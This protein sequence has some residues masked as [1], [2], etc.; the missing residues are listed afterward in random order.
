MNEKQVPLL[1]RISY[2]LGDTA[3]NLIFA[4]VTSYLMFFYTD[5]FGLNMAAVGTLFLVA[6]IIDAFDGPAYG[7][8]IDRTSTKWGKSRPYFLWLAVPFGVVAVL[9]FMTPDL[10]PGGK[11]IYAYVTYILLGVLYAGVNIPLSSLLPSLT[12]SS[13]E[14]TVVNT[15][16]MVGGQV[17]GLIVNAAVLPLVAFFGG[18]NQQDGFFYTMLLFASVGVILF[19]VTFANTR[20]RV[21]SN[22][23]KPIPFKEGIKALKANYPWWILLIVNVLLFIAVVMA[24]QSSIYYLT[25]NLGR[26]D[27]VPLFNGL[28]ALMLIGVLLVPLM[29]KYIGKRNTLLLG[30]SIAG[31]GQLILYSAADSASVNVLL[32]GRV[33]GMAGLGLVTGLKFAMIADTVDYGEWKSGVRAQ[34]LLMAASTFGVKFGMGIGGAIAAWI[35]SSGGYVANQQQTPSALLAI[36][37]NFIWVPLICYIISMI[38]IMFYRLD[39]V[40]SQIRNELSTKYQAAAAALPKAN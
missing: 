19:F 2:G 17:G 18:G 3:S 27:L 14:R 15:Y 22:D 5:V 39:K 38:L 7:I 20:E 8:L 13:Q 30:F 9:T 11:V 26:K 40:E 33:L 21:Q 32:I 25:Y 12:S 6:R 4:V 24:N 23:N 31:A 16:R 29:A 28:S 34:G 1:E 37:F 35:M 36:Q 10:S